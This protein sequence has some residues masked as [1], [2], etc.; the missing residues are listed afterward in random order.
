M[1]HLD[2][3]M[4]NFKRTYGFNKSFD[5]MISESD[6]IVSKFRNRNS[7]V[8]TSAGAT[9]DQKRY[10]NGF[11]YILSTAIEKEIGPAVE[12]H[13]FDLKRLDVRQLIFDYEEIMAAKHIESGSD[14]N[15]DAYEGVGIFLMDKVA[16]RMQTYSKSLPDIWADKIKSGKFD[17]NKMRSITDAAFSRVIGNKNETIDNILREQKQNQ[18]M[19]DGKIAD[20]NDKIEFDEEERKNV[21]LD[22]SDI[23]S[24]VGAER[25][26]K[27]AIIMR[28]AL[29]RVVERRTI[30][31]YLWPGNW[32][33]IFR[34]NRYIDK[35]SEQIAEYEKMESGIVED[36]IE[37]YSD[38]MTNAHESINNEKEKMIAAR[39]FAR[40]QRAQMASSA[41]SG[42]EKI[43]VN[44]K[45]FNP[46]AKAL[47][48]REQAI[49]EIEKLS[50]LTK[51]DAESVICTAEVAFERLKTSKYTYMCEQTLISIFEESL[52]IL[53]D[54]YD[55]SPKEAAI[56]AQKV[57]NF[58]IKNCAPEGLFTE[59]EIAKYADNY[60]VK[61][62]GILKLALSPLKEKNTNK[63]C[64]EIENEFS[65]ESIN[66]HL[67]DEVSEGEKSSVIEENH[68]VRE[69]IIE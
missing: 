12:G 21:N 60:V 37:N 17:I 61:N 28:E 35:L 14:R 26:V 24:I 63:L 4:S 64:Q 40:E 30:A 2:E 66:V 33:S 29:N 11:F 68:R 10:I 19:E 49:K 59:E 53:A 43:H 47:D 9:D 8:Q 20:G 67:N 57:T 65:K 5:E 25:G 32:P 44:D 42:K 16:A 7:L 39:T 18:R 3:L 46:S 31:T 54:D 36:V 55:I 56:R 34:E 13:D 6:R 15:R 45:K 48:P 69:S 52:S 58:V 27:T 38:A 23:H 51:D 62:D 50:G 22:E 41:D 1:A